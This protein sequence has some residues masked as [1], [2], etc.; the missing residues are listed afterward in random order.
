MLSCLCYNWLTFYL[1]YIKFQFSSFP[2]VLLKI[3]LREELF[4]LSPAS[5]NERV[6]K[7]NVCQVMLGMWYI[8][9]N[10]Y[11]II[12]YYNL[13]IYILLTFTNYKNWKR[14]K[15]MVSWQLKLCHRHYGWTDVTLT[16]KVPSP[17]S[18]CCRV[19]S[20][21]TKVQGEGEGSFCGWG[22]AACSTS[23]CF[24]ETARNVQ[25]GIQGMV[26]TPLKCLCR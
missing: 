23:V 19:T 9:Y 18:F 6:S 16:I 1:Q 11:I 2:I 10:L 17:G 13:Y 4:L 12:I 20:G 7:Q 15:V 5:I 22:I 26:N 14:E 21:C 3:L 8:Y 25:E 24:L